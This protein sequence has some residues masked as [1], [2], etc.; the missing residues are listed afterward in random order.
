MCLQFS[1]YFVVHIGW[2]RITGSQEE[3]AFQLIRMHVY[4]QVGFTQF[5]VPI[6]GDV[7]TVHDLAEQVTQIVPGYL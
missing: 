2:Y 6:I 4:F 3:F 5:S 7:S 1:P